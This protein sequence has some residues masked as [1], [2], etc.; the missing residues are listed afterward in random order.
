MTNVLAAPDPYTFDT[1]H[2]TDE[3]FFSFLK[4]GN[5]SRDVPVEEVTLGQRGKHQ[6]HQIWSFDDLGFE[7][8]VEEQ[9]FVRSYMIDR[10]EIAALRRLGYVDQDRVQLKR[11]AHRFLRV[12]EVQR[13]IEEAARRMMNKL[14]ITAERVNQQIAC[15]A[16]TDVHDVVQFT[17]QGAQI[18][19]SHLWPKHAR[20]SLKSVK[21]GQ[22]GV[23]LEFH[24]K[25]KALDFLAKQTGL[26][27][28]EKDAALA[29]AEAAA[30]LAVGK[31]LDVVGRAQEIKAAKVISDQ[32][33]EEARDAIIE[34]NR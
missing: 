6:A 7:L 27:S 28:S 26:D 9:L 16:F 13:A 22:F 31:I 4:S 25:H 19:P 12:A 8:T 1:P 2:P 21:N 34:Q 5:I 33:K 24:D 14:E 10:N 15:I 32:R 29:Q 11:I 30:Q 17:D 20:V 18:L 23:N 3:E